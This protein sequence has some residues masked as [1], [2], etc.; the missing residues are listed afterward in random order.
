MRS[1]RLALRLQVY[2]GYILWRVLPYCERANAGRGKEIFARKRKRMRNSDLREMARDMRKNIR[3]FAG[4]LILRCAVALVLEGAILL[5]V[6]RAAHFPTPAYLALFFSV[7]LPFGLIVR[8]GMAN[9]ALIA[10][11]TTRVRVADL[12]VAF[13]G[14]RPFL[15]ALIPASLVC[16]LVV[17]WLYISSPYIYTWQYLNGKVAVRI[18]EKLFRQGMPIFALSYAFVR[19]IAGQLSYAIFLGDDRPLFRV[20]LRGFGRSILT[21]WRAI[22][23]FLFL[24]V[25]RV[26]GFCVL[27][28]IAVCFVGSNEQAL[29]IFTYVVIACA[30]IW[31]AWRVVPKMGLAFAGL[32]IDSFQKG[33]KTRNDE[34]GN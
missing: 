17:A 19:Y 13:T 21:I 27:V 15:R 34:Q 11:K 30:Q 2:L 18:N 6:V 33:E 26:V 7:F 25:P 8:V 9:V 20:L 12:F 10:W 1:S 3:G 14:W 32:A 31:A 22:R 5:V 24:S 4:V 23:M 16:I 28:V 29:D